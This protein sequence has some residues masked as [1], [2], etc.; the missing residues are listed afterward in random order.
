MV[1][2]AWAPEDLICERCNRPMREPGT[3]DPHDGSVPAESPR[4]CMPCY[5]NARG[6]RGWTGSTIADPRLVRWRTRYEAERRARGIPPGGTR[7]DDERGD[8]YDR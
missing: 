2:V 3:T 1:I 6:W 4:R 8:R 5:R 7:L